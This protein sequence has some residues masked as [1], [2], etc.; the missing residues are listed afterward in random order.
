[1]KY[2]VK[3]AT[4]I[5]DVYRVMPSTTVVDFE[6]LYDGAHIRMG[7]TGGYSHHAIV[8]KIDEK[9]RT[10]NVIEI[11]CE[12]TPTLKSE[13]RTCQKYGDVLLVNYQEKYSL[14]PTFK[15]IPHQASV[16]AAEYFLKHEDILKSYTSNQ[17]MNTCENFAVSCT[18]GYS[19]GFQQ[20]K[21]L[22]IALGALNMI[23]NT[24]I[25]KLVEQMSTK[26]IFTI[27]RDRR[28]LKLKSEFCKDGIIEY[29]KE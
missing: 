23:D 14:I 3:T 29:E 20:L 2:Q 12:N 16:A 19:F 15:R 13:T 28:V 5:K 17:L 24:V 10:F 1:M 8:T 25:E 7:S 4:S 11:N 26:Q 22:I 21:Q 18:L 27:D 9:A 6:N